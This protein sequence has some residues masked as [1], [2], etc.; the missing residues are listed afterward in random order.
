MSGKECPPGGFHMWSGECSKCTEAE[1]GSCEART[2]K[3]YGGFAPGDMVTR[4]ALGDPEPLIVIPWESLGPACKG[5]RRGMVAYLRRSGTRS[6]TELYNLTRLSPY[7]E[8][9]AYEEMCPFEYNQAKAAC[10]RCSWAEECKKGDTGHPDI[11]AG[12]RFLIRQHERGPAVTRGV[13]FRAKGQELEDGYVAYRFANGMVSCVSLQRGI[14]P[15]QQEPEQQAEQPGAGAK[16]LAALLGLPVAATRE[17]IYGRAGRAKGLLEAYPFMKG[18]LVRSKH[19]GAKGR[20]RHTASEDCVLVAL[21]EGVH[22]WS[23][24]GALEVVSPGKLREAVNVLATHAEEQEMT[25]KER[26]G[27]IGVPSTPAADEDVK[28]VQVL[29]NGPV[30]GLL[31]AGQSADVMLASRGTFFRGDT[32]CSERSRTVGVYTGKSR[33]QSDDGPLLLEIVH[34]AGVASYIPRANLQL[35]KG[36]PVRHLLSQLADAF[37][38]QSDANLNRDAFLGQVKGRSGEHPGYSM[39]VD[40][41]G[42][43]IAKEKTPCISWVCEHGECGGHGFCPCHCHAGEKVQQPQ[44]RAALSPSLGEGT[45]SGVR[46]P[47]CQAHTVGSC[48]EKTEDLTL[49]VQR[50]QWSYLCPLHG[51]V[52][53]QIL[54]RS[55]LECG[56]ARIHLTDVY[57]F[58]KGVHEACGLCFGLDSDE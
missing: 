27:V 55:T 44:Y 43:A 30:L 15:L 38:K 51:S 56:H 13:Y 41:A 42:P 20:V 4:E 40:A 57:S 39:H 48:L 3:A 17:Q 2:R 35:E 9:E 49:P 54:E 16:D 12:E 7:A 10:L 14:K 6:C 1:S 19:T 47:T 25:R 46:C 34:R 23:R 33:R 24:P 53:Q 21:A 29:P 26:E 11:K 50:K 22:S 58:A 52:D 31:R 5:R 28:Y 37:R 32:L 36:G 8:V 18:D 45:I